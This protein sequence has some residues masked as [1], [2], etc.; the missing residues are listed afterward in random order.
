MKYL[1]GRHVI[2]VSSIHVQPGPT[3]YVPPLASYHECGYS[4]PY[5]QDVLLEGICDE[6]TFLI[7]V[8]NLTIICWKAC[9]LVGKCDVE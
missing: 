3:T 7:Y 9:L 5:P 4:S 1:G 2:H 6:I 8:R